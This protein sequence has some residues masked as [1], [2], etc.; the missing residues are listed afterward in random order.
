MSGTQI[1]Y[2]R[3][4]GGEAGKLG[5]SPNM[6]RLLHNMEDWWRRRGGDQGICAEKR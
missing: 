4:A 2:W 1:L 6:G 3:V 5:R